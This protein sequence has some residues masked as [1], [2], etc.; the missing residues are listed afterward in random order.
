VLGRSELIADGHILDIS[1]ITFSVS[2]LSSNSENP[3]VFFS[4]D[5]CAQIINTANVGG[6]AAAFSKLS[7]SFINLFNFVGH[8]DITYNTLYNGSI[9]N[10]PNVL[11]L[12]V[13][14]R[15]ALQLT[16]SDASF[17]VL[18]N[19]STSIY[20]TI[21]NTQ[22]VAANELALS[23]CYRA[24]DLVGNTVSAHSRS[25][26]FIKVTGGQLS[27]DPS[28]NLFTLPSSGALGDLAYGAIKSGSFR[29]NGI[30]TAVPLT[31]NENLRVLY[32]GAPQVS[33]QFKIV[34]C[35][36]TDNVI[37]NTVYANS[38]WANCAVGVNNVAVIKYIQLDA[39]FNSI[40]LNSDVRAQRCIFIVLENT[41]GTAGLVTGFESLPAFSRAVYGRVTSSAWSYLYAI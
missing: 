40:D 2:S 33:G 22:K 15:A 28:G 31:L 10:T 11:R 32:T 39:S 30:N 25:T 16:V 6:I 23:G 14:P 24:Y 20:Y 37:T 38:M 8:I 4:F 9:S 34:V 13:L 29:F 41:A 12:I 7:Y 36:K 18:P 1:G 26:T 5:K 17:N 3:K 35:V 21:K 27:V 19:G